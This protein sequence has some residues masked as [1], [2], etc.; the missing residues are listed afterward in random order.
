[1]LLINTEVTWLNEVMNCLNEI[2]PKM[3]KYKI[4]VNFNIIIWWKM[5]K[6]ELT[7]CFLKETSIINAVVFPSC[8]RVITMNTGQCYG[9]MRPSQLYMWASLPPDPLVLWVL[10]LCFYW[11]ASSSLL[12]SYYLLI[13]LSILIHQVFFLVFFSDV[14]WDRL[15]QFLQLCIK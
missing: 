3:L 10:V 7:P 11:Q 9:T 8:P 5:I 13:S 1:M 2:L 12:W 15:V 14:M 4:K 6:N